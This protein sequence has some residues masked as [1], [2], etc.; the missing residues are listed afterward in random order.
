MTKSAISQFSITAPDLTRYLSDP[1]DSAA[2]ALKAILK[3]LEGAEDSIFQTRMVAL[4]I[5]SERELWRLDTDPEYGVPFKSMHRWIQ[6][7]FPRTRYALE[8][9]STQQALVGVKIE[10]LAEMKRCTA[11]LL[12]DKGVSDSC[13]RDPAIIEAAKTASE[14]EFREKLNKTH[15]QHLERFETLKLTYPSGDMGQVKRYL[16]W[17][18]GKADLE[19][20]DY[21]GALLY[22][23]IH[24]NEE[25]EADDD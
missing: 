11:V 5:I 20:D 9:N 22:L 13:R 2:A 7:T 15:G 1:P 25:H 12:A 17:V 3:S 21:Q 4:R 18:A 16:G 19:P 8:A 14:S 10:D 6:C 23:A 24:E